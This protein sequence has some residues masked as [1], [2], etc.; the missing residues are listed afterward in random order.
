VCGK[1]TLKNQ[2]CWF[3]APRCGI[4]CGKK[5]KCGSH[6]C[7]KTCHR[8]G[9][10]EDVDV[11]GGH[12][13]QPCRKQ[14]RHCEHF[15]ADPCHAPFDCKED[16]PC[17]GKTL[18]T[19]E[20]QNRKQEVK[21]Q[22]TQNNPWPKREPLKCDDECLRL[23]RNRRLADALNI[24]PATHTD[25]HVPYSDTTMKMYKEN[26]NWA[27]TQERQ[28]RLF[29]SAAD[30]KRLAFKPMQPNQRAFIHSLAEDFGLDSE[31]QDP[32]GIRH[33]T[34]FKTPRFVSAPMKTL[35]QCLKIQ[36]AAAAAARPAPVRVGVDQQH[37]FNAFLLSSLRFA[38]TI[39]E[40]DTALAK[41]FASPKAASLLFSTS[42]LPTEQILITASPKATAAAALASSRP[43]T[44]QGIELVLKDL[45]ALLA[46]TVSRLGLASSVA[47]CRADASLNIIRRE[48]DP[49]DPTDPNGGGAWSMVA[50]RSAAKPMTVPQGRGLGL[51][52][53][54][55]GFMA[56]RKEGVLKLS[57]K[58]RKEKREEDAVVVKPEEEEH[59]VQ[60]ELLGV[61]EDRKADV[62]ADV[63]HQA[64]D[65]E[66]DALT[67]A[68]TTTV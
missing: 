35:A 31:S 10:C 63:R 22:A 24:D 18:I 41:V 67:Q 11:P 65:T 4:P 39:D 33:V 5:L 3:E 19:C 54:S 48:G 40:V 68:V 59:I 34:L 62:D 16:K 25:N 42:F 61:G 7:E 45:K 2:P 53:A 26:V 32:E 28:F 38:L 6:D 20:C 49:N 57:L 1:K 58:G 43:L 52:S 15:C 66:V 9:D 44:P 17:Q 47:L 21:C 13:S 23:E 50:K 56:L 37:A 29:A 8:D 51:Q 55:R 36:L 12:C 46:E 27:E 60:G 64:D 30:E 14:K